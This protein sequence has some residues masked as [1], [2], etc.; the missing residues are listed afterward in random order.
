MLVCLL[1]FVLFVFVVLFVCP[2]V[3]KKRYIYNYLTIMLSN[4]SFY[5]TN[6]VEKDIFKMLGRLCFS[7]VLLEMLLEI[8]HSH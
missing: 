8:R 3:S 5:Q 7:K 4:T 1:C 6:K 2:F